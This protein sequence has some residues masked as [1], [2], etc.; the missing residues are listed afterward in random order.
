MLV[1]TVEIV[2]LALA[3]TVRPT[4]LAATDALLASSAPRR[5]MTAYVVAGLAFTMAFGLIVALVLGGIDAGSAS[6]GARST[7]EIVSGIVALVLAALVWRGRLGGD[8][9]SRGAPHPPRRW[10]GLLE[11]HRTLRTAMLAGPATHLPGLFYLIALNLIVA[12]RLTSRTVVIEVALFNVI[13]FALPLVALAVSI[14]SPELACEG[15]G[16]ANAWAVRHARTI[17]LAG[18]SGVGLALVV[19]GVVHR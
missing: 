5:L 18:L 3:T 10:Q 16:A 11:K 14:V 17:L 12:N 6:S 15:I 4:S 2:L 19:T 8:G 7:A 1:L 9:A 13:W